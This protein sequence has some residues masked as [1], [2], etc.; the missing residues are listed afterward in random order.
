MTQRSLSVNLAAL[1]LVAF[2][3]VLVSLVAPSP[4]TRTSFSPEKAMESVNSR[5]AG[6]RNAFCPAVRMGIFSRS[7]I[8][9]EK[10]NKIMFISGSPLRDEALIGCDGVKYWF[11]IRSFDNGNLYFCD[12]AELD[13]TRLIP[14][15]RPEAV[16]CMAWIDEV[17]G[18]A[19]PTERGFRA[20]SAKGRFRRVVEFDSEKILGQELIVD[21]APV[22]S[23]RGLEFGEFSGIM[24][25]TRAEATWHEEGMSGTFTM[26]GWTVNI[27][28]PNIEEPKGFHRK[29][30]KKL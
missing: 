8:F 10:P 20:E 30:L 14:L 17:E 1:A 16:V 18:V 7:L 12:L 22:G 15:M 9:Y 27:P 3:V 25:P 29:S 13:E 21:G 2:L 28:T 4:A 6:V 5:M 11:W 24:L 19:V 26:D 23:V